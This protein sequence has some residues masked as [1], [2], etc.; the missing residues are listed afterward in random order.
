MAEEDEDADLIEEATALMD[1]F[2]KHMR[3]YVFQHC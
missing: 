1:E 3:N 2:E